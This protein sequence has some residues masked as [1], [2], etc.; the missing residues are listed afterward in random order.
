[1][2]ETYA[3]VDALMEAVDFKPST[4]LEVGVEKFIGWF[5]AWR[6]NR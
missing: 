4:P 2:P 6:G 1:V 3:N 5:R